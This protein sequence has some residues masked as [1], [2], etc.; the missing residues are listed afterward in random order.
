M[1]VTFSTWLILQYMYIVNME[2]ILDQIYYIFHCTQCTLYSTQLYTVHILKVIILYYAK[3]SILAKH[4]HII[5][6]YAKRSILAK[7]I[8]AESVFFI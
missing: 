7:H 3:R 4:I 2:Y 1:A 8:S 5:L 6:Y